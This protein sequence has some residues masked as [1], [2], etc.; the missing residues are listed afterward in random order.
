M[1][2][3][4][5][6]GGP[7]PHAWVLVEPHLRLSKQPGP[8]LD[9]HSGKDRSH[10]CN[11]GTKA[12]PLVS[13]QGLGKEDHIHSDG[14]FRWRLSPVDMRT[15]GLGPR[16]WRLTCRIL[17]KQ[18]M[19]L[20]ATAPGTQISGHQLPFWFPFST[21]EGQRPS[22]E[23]GAQTPGDHPVHFYGEQIGLPSFPLTQLGWVHFTLVC[24]AIDPPLSPPVQAALL[25]SRE[26]ASW[27]FPGQQESARTLWAQLHRRKLRSYQ[28]VPLPL[29]VLIY[30]FHSH[31]HI[32]KK[33]MTIHFLIK[34]LHWLKQD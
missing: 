7:S 23:L 15:W 9:L 4:A 22:R 24:N 3:V 10:W 13:V 19:E 28:K 11:H 18:H 2:T 26:H 34:F 32:L 20:E 25:R 1:D 30:V 5:P 6:F 33:C 14:H 16:W 17:R 8:R 29:S 12:C 31:S 27:A 21:E